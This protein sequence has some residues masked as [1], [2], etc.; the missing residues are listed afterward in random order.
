MSTTPSYAIITPVRDEAD[1]LHRLAQ[2]LAKQT[3]LPSAWVVVDDGSTDGSRDVVASIAREHP[4]IR[5]QSTGGARLARGAPVVR[6]FHAALE[7]LDPFPDV[8]VKLDADMSMESDHFER[9]LHEFARDPRLGVAGGIGYEEQADGVWRQRHG[10]GPAV[11]GGCRVY[12]RECLQDILPLE[13]RM[14]WDTLDLMKAN[15]RGWK[16][17]VFYDLPFRHHRAEGERDGGRLR[18]AIIQGAAAHYMGY[19]FSYLLVRALYRMLR[20]PSALG[21]LGG[22]LA[23]RLRRLPRCEDAELRAYVRRQQRLRN[24]PLR[25]R[26]ARRPRASLAE[27]TR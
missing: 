15:L 4:W 22:Y 19:R 27:P 20:D 2:C 3:V 26:E 14:G 17:D 23:A 8:V 5:L 18:T 24:L 12:R 16:T 21:L 25:A 7:S 1:N 6:A 9:L 11:W 13:E 10:T